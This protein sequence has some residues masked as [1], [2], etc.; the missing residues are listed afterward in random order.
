VDNTDA[1]GR[2][3]GCDDAGDRQP[4]SGEDPLL[5]FGHSRLRKRLL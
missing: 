2:Q 3:A 1:K 5:R 4:P